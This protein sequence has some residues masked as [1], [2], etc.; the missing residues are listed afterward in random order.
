MVDPFQGDR[1]TEK[2]EEE[3][4]MCFT[5]IIGDLPELSIAFGDVGQRC[6]TGR[7]RAC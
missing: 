1:I 6:P 3:T 7:E 5:T 2:G 4:W